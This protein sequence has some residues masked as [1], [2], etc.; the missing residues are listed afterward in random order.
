MNVVQRGLQKILTLVTAYPSLT[1]CVALALGVLS[2]L[3]TVANLGFLTSQS[4]LISPNDRLMKL[5]EEMDPFDDLDTLVVAV[6]NHDPSRSLKFLHTLVPF[7]EADRAHYDQVFFR[8]DPKSFRRWALLYLGV[9]D[10]LTLRDSLQEHHDFIQGII[11]SPTLTNF[12]SQINQ[13]MTSKMVDELFTGFLEEKSTGGANEPRDLDFLIQVLREMKQWLD[14]KA[15]PTSPWESFFTKKSWAVTSEEGYFWTENKHYLVLLITPR[16]IGKGFSRG[17]ESLKALRNTIARVQADYPGIR[18][19]VTGPA[20]LNQDE[21]GVALKD[22]SLATF[23]SLAGL[24]ILLVLFWR[25]FRRP[26]LEITQLLVA[27][28]LTFGLT[29]LFIGHLNI[30]SVSFAPMLLGLGID[31]G[32]HWVSRYREEYETRGA[33]KKEA[34]RATMR[35]LGPGILLAGLSAALSFF[36]LVLTGFRGLMELGIICSIGLMTATIMTLCLLPAL[37]LMFDKEKSTAILPLSSGFVKPLLQFTRKQALLVLVIA[38]LGSIFS[39]WGA[40]RIKFDLNMLR[41]QSRG[42]ESVKWEK[43]LIEDSKLHSMQGA[44]F[45]RSLEEA[46]KKTKALETLPSVSRVE[47]VANLLPPDQEEKARLLREMKPLLAGVHPFQISNRAVNPSELIEIL[48]RIRFKMLDSGW[49]VS[50]A[51]K[52]QMME[53]RT[54]I[55]DLRQ[56]FRSMDKSHLLDRLQAFEAALIRDLNDKLDLLLANINAPP[57]RIEDLPKPLLQRFVSKNG[58]YLIRVF[59]AHNIWEPEFLGKFVHDLIAADPDAIGDPVT[60]YVFTKAF[61]D[62]CILAAL[63]AVLFIFLFLLLTFRN[64]VSALL[65]MMPL[66][67][68]TV[69]T[70]GVMDGLGVDLN[71]AN[72]IFLPLV[73]GAGVEYGIIIVQRWR[74]REAGVVL[75]SSTGQGVI[76]AG[77]TTTVGFG[78]LILSSHRGL[79]SLGLLTM[80]GSLVILVAAVLLLPALLQLLTRRKDST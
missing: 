31:Y 57:M 59:P 24:T 62:A 21:M 69:W 50:P 64:I 53:A 42:S 78:S 14:G 29:T 49:E 40:S 26:L 79:Y 77:L 80:I 39:C 22:M 15:S 17:Q 65:A 52:L 4:E 27:L 60:L 28:S 35:Q 46:E 5:S 23:F 67:V 30:L 8:V 73:V 36:P 44:V 54:L 47:S 19:G 48:G 10:F 16:K 45:A 18:V 7:L 9:K 43:K 58:L 63:Y 11:Q 75:P 61:R 3:Y 13:K 71:L 34:L 32:V 55:G 6:E 25:G 51:V 33:P 68:G 41:L 72:S 56:R 20:A 38:C 76:L 1:L 12:F 74:Q 70:F 2:I 37:I 66:A